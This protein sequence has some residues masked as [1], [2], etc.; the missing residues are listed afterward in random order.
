MCIL[1]II[2]IHLFI[3]LSVGLSSQ[4]FIFYCCWQNEYSSFSSPSSFF[5]C[6]IRYTD[7][8]LLCAWWLLRVAPGPRPPPPGLR[9]L[10]GCWRS[11]MPPSSSSSCR[12]CV[13]IYVCVHVNTL[14]KR[15]PKKGWV[16]IYVCV[17]M[18]NIRTSKSSSSYSSS[19][20]NSSNSA[21]ST[22]RLFTAR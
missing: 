15:E 7:T 19:S 4:W 5:V 20:P 8:V 21:G 14:Q 18:S 2:C 9:P 3:S 13:C 16:R 22:S 1:S 6:V 17:C 12:A 11:S 10:G